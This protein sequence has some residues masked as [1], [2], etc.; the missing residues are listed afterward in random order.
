MLIA[1]S[2]VSRSR[3]VRNAIMGVCAC[4]A[5]SGW[6]VC[7]GDGQR[8]S[9]SAVVD[10]TNLTGIDSKTMIAVG[11]PMQQSVAAEIMAETG[12]LY[13]PTKLYSQRTYHNRDVNDAVLSRT[14]H[15]VIGTKK[16]QLINM[17]DIS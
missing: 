12:D 9:I 14:G 6:C 7:T 15:Y 5:R 1:E 10:D 17:G 2:S 4:C 16:T 11:K 3:N 13:L 8:D